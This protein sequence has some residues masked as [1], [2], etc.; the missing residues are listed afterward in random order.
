M[1]LIQLEDDA[2]VALNI[3]LNVALHDT[4]LTL[5]F[6]EKLNAAYFQLCHYD[7]PSMEMRRA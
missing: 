3:F 4:I 1:K 2:A 6:A 7:H 5:D